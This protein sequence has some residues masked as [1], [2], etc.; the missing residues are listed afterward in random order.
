MHEPTD[1][2]SSRPPPLVGQPI[3]QIGLG[4]LGG[5]I[6]QRLRSRGRRVV[7]F[8]VAR[9]R[10]E[11][12]AAAGVEAAATPG[13]VVDRATTVVLCLPTSDVAAEVLEAIEPR[14]TA[15]HLIID[16]TTGR[17]DTMAEF[18]ARLGA[19]G[20]RYLDAC[21]LGSSGQARAGEVVLSVGGTAA[22]FAAARGLLEDLS[23]RVVHVGPGG[24]GARFKL[25][26]NLV[27]GLHRAVL[28]EALVF[29]ERTGLEAARVL[30]VLPGTP[31]ASAVMTT[32]GQKMLHRDFSPQATVAQHL[33]DVRLMLE[34][35]REAG[36]DLP[37]S[38]THAALLEAV[39]A[40]GRAAADNTAI[41]TA[42]ETDRENSRVQ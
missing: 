9:A 14:L 37:L 42:F 31:A 21:V 3:G 12:L 32:K 19:R 22:A 15:A 23:A 4:L 20:V 27:L 34:T 24:S 10:L 2:P 26:H 41:I 7:G 40:A 18:G 33:K 35:A 1:Q 25:V 5:A 39:V 16:T 29:A 30:E 11:D 6:A 28:A 36:L 17:P 38:A 8:D 13:E